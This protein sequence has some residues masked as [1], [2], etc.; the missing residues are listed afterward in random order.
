M[1]SENAEQHH[2]QLVSKFVEKPAANIK[3]EHLVNITSS[4]PPLDILLRALE[5][6]LDLRLA[7]DRSDISVRFGDVKSLDMCLN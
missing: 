2:D 5:Q 7:A 6:L 4:G 3:A 1:Y